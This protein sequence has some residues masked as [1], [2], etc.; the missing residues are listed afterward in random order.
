MN[1]LAFLTVVEAGPLEAQVALL[2]E[3]LRRFGGSLGQCPLWVVRPR[4]GPPLAED[5]LALFAGHDV[6]Y[7]DAPLNT[8]TPGSRDTDSRLF[9]LLNKPFAAAHLESQLEGEVD[10]LVLMEE[11]KG[12]DH[13]TQARVLMEH[14]RLATK[15][16]A[17]NLIIN[18][19][20][21]LQTGLVDL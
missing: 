8:A 4:E 10:T 7:L 9:G 6:T 20:K 11:L 5:T 16:L 12:Q 2:V 17:E 18:G 13:A 21:K 3:S 15:S 19:N 14:A 1:R